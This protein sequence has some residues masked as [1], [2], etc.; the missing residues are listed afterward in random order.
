LCF[1]ACFVFL[2]VRKGAAHH[3]AG[4]RREK[5]EGTYMG[6]DTT[7]SKHTIKRN[8]TFNTLSTHQALKSSERELTAA[9]A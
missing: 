6:K 7:R 3:H 9:R 2:C 4:R 1:F 8:N 5:H